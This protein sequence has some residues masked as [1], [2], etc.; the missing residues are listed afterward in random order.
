[1]ALSSTPYLSSTPRSASFTRNCPNYGYNER[2]DD[3]ELPV[4]GRT[5]VI[6]G[7]PIIGRWL[8]EWR[9]RVAAGGQVAAGGWVAI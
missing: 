7:S 4:S 3:F 5:L 8:E 2:Y 6:T 1:M 9:R